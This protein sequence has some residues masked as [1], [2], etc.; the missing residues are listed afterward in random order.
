MATVTLRGN[1]FNTSGE[2][3]AV[4]SPAPQFSLVGSDLSDVSSESFAGKRVVL[5]IFPSIDTPTCAASVRAFNERAAE[6]DNT[7]V[8]C[9][10]EDLPFAAGRFCGAE[11][12]ANVTTGSAFRS[13]F[14]EAYGVK[15]EEG[16]LAGLTA[17]AVVVIDEDGTVTHTQLVGEIADEPD[18]DAAL[19]ALG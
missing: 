16:P 19:N 9:V 13:D 6:L 12:I 15:L 7:V 3:P 2:L 5:N 14:A 18:Y 10:S 11:G 8:L 1:P 4:G 17:R